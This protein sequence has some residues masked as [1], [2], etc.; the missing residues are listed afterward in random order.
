MLLSIKPGHVDNILSGSKTVELRR[1][2]PQVS[3]GQPIAIYA[4]MPV[5]AVVATCRV[6]KVD[7]ALPEI[8]KARHLGQ[9]AISATDFDA[10]FAGSG[11][12]VA[13]HVDEVAAL[14]NPVTLNEIRSRRSAYNP[15]QTW[16]FFNRTQL[17]DL[18]GHHL[19][20]HDLST[21][22]AR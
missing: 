20:H 18:L 17:R 12:A 21:L 9:A 2:R 15:P 6:R 16:H 19:A 14:D 3:A 11:H 4:T 10:Y 1:I 13:I 8:I 5:G 7:V 22:L